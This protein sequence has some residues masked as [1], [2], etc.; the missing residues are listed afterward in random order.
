MPFANRAD[1]L[2]AIARDL[3]DPDGNTWTSDDLSRA[4]D[5]AL[6]DLA[7]AVGAPASVD[8]PATGSDTY[9]LS[10]Y[11]HVRQ[12]V[13][14]EWPAD[15]QP[16]AYLRFHIW[17]ATLRLLDAAP[18]AGETLRLHYRRA[19]AVDDESSDVP[20]DLAELAVLGA[21]AYA[22][23]QQ[24]ARTACTVNV[25]GWV[26]RRYELQSER[27]LTRFREA[28][29]ELRQA[30]ENPPFHPGQTPAWYDERD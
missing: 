21:R 30:R 1:F 19:F 8:V 18:P 9:D 23:L 13:A 16:P 29:A 27:L 26:S 14:V 12:I 22:L 4:L 17:G 25:D 11:P 7:D 6:D 24:A 28:L 3:G 2:A 10:G 5:H 15:E 20:A